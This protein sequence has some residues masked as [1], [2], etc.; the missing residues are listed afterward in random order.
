[1]KN[2]KSTAVLIV[3]LLV[4]LVIGGVLGEA[5]GGTV[6]YLAYGKTIGFDPVTID[7][8]IML[9][10][11]GLKLTINVAGIIGLFLSLFIYSRL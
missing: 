8:G 10:T 2:R 5:F 6:K 4:G 1:M 11:L 9:I 3:L 7:L